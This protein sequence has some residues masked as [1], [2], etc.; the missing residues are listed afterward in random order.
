MAEPTDSAAWRAL[1]PSAKRLLAHV[2][3]QLVSH[4]R[5]AISR[6]E[7]R[8]AEGL[9]QASCTL[10]VQQVKALGF[11]TVSTGQRRCHVFHRS[12]EWQTLGE[13]EVTQRL[14]TV[15]WPRRRPRVVLRGRS[16]SATK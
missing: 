16:A 5:V 12:D 15:R 11:V 1:T 7:F 4:A 10:G 6:S 3:Q 9:C 8:R 13:A 2:D 14:A